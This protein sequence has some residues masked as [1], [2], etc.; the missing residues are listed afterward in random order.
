MNDRHYENEI[1]IS[2]LLLYCISKWRSMLVFMIVFAL[3]A[4][5]LKAFK[6]TKQTAAVENTKNAESEYYENRIPLA[7]EKIE[8]LYDY[9]EKSELMKANVYS[10]YQTT[11][12][13][14]ISS[15]EA[16]LDSIM[17]SLKEFVMNGSLF[18]KIEDTTGIYTAK[19]LPY[20]VGFTGKIRENVVTEQD[21]F[22]ITVK[23]RNQQET[24]KLNRLVAEEIDRFAEGLKAFY[25]LESIDEID[26]VTFQISS[27]ELKSYQRS[28]YDSIY[29]EKELLANLEN[30]LGGMPV[31]ENP[32]AVQESK[33][34]VI[35][36]AGAGAAAG[37]LLAFFGWAAVFVLGGRL[38][39]V[40]DIEK[41]FHLPVL[42]TLVRTKKKTAFDRLID[43]KRGGMYASMT[44]EE[45]KK[46]L[47]LTVENELKKDASLQRVLLCGSLKAEHL[48]GM[49][50]WLYEELKSLG[51]SAEEYVNIL[52]N[53]NGM[54]KIK[55]C[56][57]VILLENKEISKSKMVQDEIAVLQACDRKIKGIVLV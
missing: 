13:Y 25:G 10:M 49:E 44:I 54:E 48:G 19:E 18:K 7:K 55:D 40:L 46:I 21:N 36:F 15:A 12:N 22:T 17:A 56:D 26:S 20:L 37:L 35:L 14:R 42:G 50:K 28:I 5:G 2:N 27:P 34:D 31:S 9:V 45:Q 41:R 11:T 3:L 4:G 24:E 39:S 23:G 32:A 52:G 51:Y 47:T 33:K 8:D 38:Y 1:G 29:T 53:V 57:A 43:R 30:L 16:D 6:G